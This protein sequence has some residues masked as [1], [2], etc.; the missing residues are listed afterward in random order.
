MCSLA[1]VFL[2]L[3]F[4]CAFVHKFAGSTFIQS[5]ISNNKI[6]RSKRKVQNKNMIT[7][8]SH[9]VSFTHPPK[10]TRNELKF[11]NRRRKKEQEEEQERLRT[12]TQHNIFL[13]HFGFT[14]NV[15]IFIFILFFSSLQN[16]NYCQKQTKITKWKQ[17]QNRLD[18]V[19][20]FKCI[21]S[22]NIIED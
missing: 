10:D 20:H 4:F 12:F 14:F 21:S 9:F 13:C 5:S 3:L 15:F 19:W 7:F 2:L 17:T 8:Y 11:Q 6:P 22:S 18:F 1:H 16:K